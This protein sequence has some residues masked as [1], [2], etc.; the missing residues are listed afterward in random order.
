MTHMY[1]IPELFER[2]GVNKPMLETCKLSCLRLLAGKHLDQD[3][4]SVRSLS[5]TTVLPWI[6]VEQW[7]VICISF[8]KMA[9]TLAMLMVTMG[10]DL[11]PGRLADRLV[12]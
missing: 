3:S 2:Q 5:A 11:Q 8:S 10:G 12:A 9:S 6:R 7:N 4:Q 1:M